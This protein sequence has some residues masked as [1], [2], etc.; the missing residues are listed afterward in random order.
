[1]DPV[2]SR[3]SIRSSGFTPHGEHA[4]DFTLRLNL[5]IPRTPAKSVSIWARSV[6]VTAFTGSQ[7]GIFV[8]QRVRTSTWTS[9]TLSRAFLPPGSPLYS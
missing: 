2:R 1:M 9:R 7:P 4:V 8:R 6:T 5:S 3:T